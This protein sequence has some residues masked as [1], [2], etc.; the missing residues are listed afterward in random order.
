MLRH[1]D[2]EIVVQ[3]RD[4]SVSFPRKLLLFHSAQLST[5]LEKRPNIRAVNVDR[6]IFKQDLEIL[7][8]TLRGECE[9]TPEHHGNWLRCCLVA[10]ALGMVSVVQKCR[11]TLEYDYCR[12]VLD[13]DAQTL[14]LVE[15]RTTKDCPVRGFLLG[16]STARVPNSTVKS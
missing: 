9:L 4:G 7:E 14:E 16:M 1:W 15:K 6:D 2:D 5:F 11:D 12:Q 8:R 13:W 10:G 3:A